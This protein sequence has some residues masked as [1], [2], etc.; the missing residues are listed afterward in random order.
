[1]L[2]ALMIH[3][4]G[5]SGEGESSSGR[6]ELFGVDVVDL[7]NL[8]SFIGSCNAEDTLYIGESVSAVKSFESLT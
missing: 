4:R 8:F 6:G 5:C 3:D 1:M 2:K 7:W